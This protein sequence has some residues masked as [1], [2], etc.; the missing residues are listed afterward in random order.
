MP[1]IFFAIASSIGTPIYS[2][3][4]YTRPLIDRSFGHFVRV[5]VD[6][7]VTKEIRYKI[8]VEKQG[9]ALNMRISLNFALFCN[10]TNHYLDNFKF[11][12]NKS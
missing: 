9:Y 1:K 6:M 5:L 10:K 7:D 3:M 11:G 8:L 12:K 2:D 4:A